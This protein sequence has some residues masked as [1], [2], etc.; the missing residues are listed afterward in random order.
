[1]VK[2]SLS[3]LLGVVFPL[4]ILFVPKELI[5]IHGITVIEQRLLAIFVFAMIFWLFDTIPAFAV[6]VLVI[7]FELI[8]I[9]DGG[10]IWFREGAENPEFGRLLAYQDIFHSFG[11]PILLLFLGGF[12]LASAAAKHGLDVNLARTLIKPFGHRPSVVLFGVMCITALFSMFMSNTATTAMML[13]ILAPFFPLFDSDDPGR[14]GMALA[15]PFAANIG[16]IGTPIGTPPNIIAMNYLSR[17]WPVSFGTWMTFAVPFVIGLLTLTWL[18]LILLFPPR[19]KSIPFR[20]ERKVPTTPRA[21]VVYITFAMTILLWLVGE[22]IGLNSYVVGMVPIAVF[23]ASGIITSSDV[24]KMSWNVLWLMAG[25]IAL[26]IGVEKTGL[27]QNMVDSIPFYQF[28]PTVIVIVSVLLS[29]TLAT[30]ISHTAAVNLIL[31]IITVLGASLPSLSAVGG[32]RTLIIGATLGASFAMLLPI[33][34]PP[35]ALAYAT[36]LFSTKHMIKAGLI[37]ECLCCLALF[38]LFFLFHYTL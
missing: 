2:T 19:L 20:F 31:P 35:N 28:S 32:S 6:S 34:T 30:F 7:F 27:S 5:P 36:N 15:V 9:S 8:M 10:L 11:S 3:L 26:G 13:T 37:V 4:V 16:G 12:F 1:M 25:G 38:T 14:I 23:L 18:A 17:A 21:V 24:K 22:M 29:M 33:S